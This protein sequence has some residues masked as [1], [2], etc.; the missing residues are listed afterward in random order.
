MAALG[1]VSTASAQTPR[2]SSIL[3]N[4]CT[5]TV[6]VSPTPCSMGPGDT[7]VVNGTGFGGTAGIVNT[8]DCNEI[9]VPSAD[10]TPTRVTGTV[11]WVSSSGGIQLETNGGQLSTPAVPYAALSAVITSIST[12]TCT[13]TPGVSATQCV[14]AAGTPFTINGSHFGPGPLTGVSGP[15]VAICD[16]TNPT[17]NS[18]DNNWLTSPS[19]TGNI[20]TAT[21][22]EAA[23]GNSIVVFSNGNQV[24][25][26]DPVPYTT[27]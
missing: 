27:C 3:V 23:C 17:I 15:Q 9:T 20:I 13:Y 2:I 24:P 14:I 19:P 18:W 6:G 11:N 21:A 26:S 10:W 8:C 16:C 22:V 5:Y 7:L 25:G 4:G 12:A 1:F